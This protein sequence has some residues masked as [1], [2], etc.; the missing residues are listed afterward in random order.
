MVENEMSDKF[1]FV[2]LRMLLDN[3][4]NIIQMNTLMI[5]QQK[6]LLITQK[7]L[8]NRCE[9]SHI[10]QIKFQ[11][12]MV[13]VIDKTNIC[14]QNLSDMHD[15]VTNV[16]TKLDNLVTEK[17]DRIESKIETMNLNN[18]KD[19]GGLTNKLYIALGSSATVV[20]SLVALLTVVYDKY[21]IVKNIEKMIYDIFQYLNIN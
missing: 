19:H 10:N 3:Y 4:Q 11:S 21:E 5:E 14:I 15:I 13:L 12:N 6:Q 7:E 17:F 9:G 8:I 1:S 20:I 18:V 2:D 16:Y